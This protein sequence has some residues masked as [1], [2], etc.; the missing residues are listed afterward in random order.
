VGRAKIENG[1]V[2][3]LPDDEPASPMGDSMI[4]RMLERYVNFSIELKMAMAK[5]PKTKP[6][7][8]EEVEARP[9]SV[10]SCPQVV[11][12]IL[13]SQSDRESAELRD[14]ALGTFKDQTDRPL[15]WYKKKAD[16]QVLADHPA[17]LKSEQPGPKKG[18][19]AKDR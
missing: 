19:R 15:D 11:D 7:E 16:E 10:P 3:P 13:L 6:S 8:R 18:K 4:F 17:G 1:K 2:S 9:G 5:D 14:A 12:E